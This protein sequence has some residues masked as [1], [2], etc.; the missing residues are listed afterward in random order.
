V[1]GRRFC[2][3]VGGRGIPGG[4]GIRKDIRINEVGK[5]KK[6]DGNGNDVLLLLDYMLLIMAMK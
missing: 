5:M 3:L 2:A 4:R 6:V 1:L